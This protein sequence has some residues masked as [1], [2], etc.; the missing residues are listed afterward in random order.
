MLQLS[1][2]ST[3]HWLSADFSERENTKLHV[4][5]R[6]S[7]VAGT[8]LQLV[9]KMTCLTLNSGVSVSSSGTLPGRCAAFQGDT[10]YS[11]HEGRIQYRWISYFINGW[12]TFPYFC[13]AKNTVCMKNQTVIFQEAWTNIIDIL[14]SLWINLGNTSSIL[15]I[16]KQSNSCW[17]AVVV[18]TAYYEQTC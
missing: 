9:N 1:D 14:I 2:L 7:M 17:C 8:Q 16:M 3:R 11:A 6:T 15:H 5:M 18:N 4:S 13:H 12:S 10:Y